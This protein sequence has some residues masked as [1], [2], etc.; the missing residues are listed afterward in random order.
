MPTLQ[1]VALRFSLRPKYTFHLVLL[2]DIL[3]HP[4]PTKMSLRSI[5]KA[6][7]S[8]DVRTDDN[9]HGHQQ[10]ALEEELRLANEAQEKREKKFKEG[11]MYCDLHRQRIENSI[12]QIRGMSLIDSAIWSP[13]DTFKLQGLLDQLTE[14]GEAA[15][16]AHNKQVDL[17]F[18]GTPPSSKQCQLV[19]D[20][21]LNTR[22]MVVEGQATA[23]STL[24]VMRAPGFEAATSDKGSQE[25]ES[26]DNSAGVALMAEAVSKLHV[27]LVEVSKATAKA[28]QSVNRPPIAVPDFFGDRQDYPAFKAN[29]Q[30]AYDGHGYQENALFSTLMSLIKG[31]AKSTVKGLINQPGALATAW[32]L[33]DARFG[34]ST[35]VLADILASCDN[36][37]DNPQLHQTTIIRHNYDA[38]AALVRN[39]N[40]MKVT[41]GVMAISSW[42][43]KF[44]TSYRAKWAEVTMAGTK[45]ANSVIDFLAV[46]ESKLL[47]QESLQPSTANKDEKKPESKQEKK[48][49]N[50]PSTE[51]SQSSYKPFQ[52]K[53]QDNQSD[54][55]GSKPQ[56]SNSQK[57]T[58]RTS[59]QP[60]KPDSKQQPTGA[61]L[62]GTKQSN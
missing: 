10:E 38:I 47:V 22:A 29:F 15:R 24:Q 18:Q 60:S 35:T 17:L 45:D 57:D 61:A 30:A 1:L 26:D 19:D 55:K 8:E 9:P 37:P 40:L 25:S 51:K 31:K 49:E 23:N 59:K 43:K 46:M 21:W 4:T 50:K 56:D 6:L 34:N 12:K 14:D 28:I 33:L 11:S 58:Q 53:K 2:I 62:T 27:N 36:L 41:T 5:I 13:A 16:E 42:Q 54:F 52:P 39:L 3:A 7:S 20:W 48:P 44:P 32:Q